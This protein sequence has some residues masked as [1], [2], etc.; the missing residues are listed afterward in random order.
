MKRI[1][2]LFMAVM[3]LTACSSQKAKTYESVNLPL[4][5]ISP[6]REYEYEGEIVKERQVIDSIEIT[7]LSLEE[8]NYFKNSYS[9][10]GKVNIAEDYKL[11]TFDFGEVINF[12]WEKELI[13]KFNI[14]KPEEWNTIIKNIVFYLNSEALV[15]D[16]NYSKYDFEYDKYNQAPF[17]RHD[18]IKYSYLIPNEYV[19]K[20]LQVKIITFNNGD[21]KPVFIDLVK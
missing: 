21:E 18:F 2:F 17:D 20:G 9:G 11:I 12:N 10:L 3:L 1:L 19:K 8:T 14:T 5:L 6:E 13:D 16:L 7:D 4:T 15:I